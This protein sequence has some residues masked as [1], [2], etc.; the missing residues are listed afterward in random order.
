MSPS[1]KDAAR[2]AQPAQAGVYHLPQGGTV[3]LALAAKQ[4][5]FWWISVDLSHARSKEDLLTILAQGLNF[6]SW[7]GN[8]WD[9]LAD[10][11]TDLSWHPAEGYV[12]VLEQADSLRAA[13]EADFLTLLAILS[14][15]AEYWRHEGLAFWSFV[16]LAAD[17]IALLP[18]LA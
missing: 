7:F 11:L 12:L 13:A 14:D 2:L 10:C 3:E 17:G 6:P 18:N 1:A 15:V 8:N 5:D 9:A 16:E 4:L